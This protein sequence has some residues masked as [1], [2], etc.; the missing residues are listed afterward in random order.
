MQLYCN[1]I[2]AI[3][4]AIVAAIIAAGLH[5]SDCISLGQASDRALDC[6]SDLFNLISSTI[7]S[8]GLLELAFSQRQHRS[9]S[10][11]TDWSNAN[12]MQIDRTVS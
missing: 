10:T 3:I 12:E 5:L 8:H 6:K 9:L 11:E 2:A 1:S 7:N 4:A